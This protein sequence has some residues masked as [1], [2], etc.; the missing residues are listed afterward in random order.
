MA[1]RRGGR[2]YK[3]DPGIQR[4]EAS[5]RRPP[6]RRPLAVCG[7]RPGRARCGEEFLGY[8]QSAITVIRPSDVVHM[9]LC[10]DP[11]AA[12]AEQTRVPRRVTDRTESET[13]I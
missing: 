13:Q 3:W 5:R 1:H 4:A 12:P 7:A 9:V 2:K 6:R 11:V 10:R 8:Q